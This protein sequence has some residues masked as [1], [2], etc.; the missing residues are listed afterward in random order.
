MRRLPPCWKNSLMPPMLR[1]TYPTFGSMPFSAERRLIYV[2]DKEKTSPSVPLPDD[3]VAEIK[4]AGT[5]ESLLVSIQE[6]LRGETADAPARVNRDMQLRNYQRRRI[7]KR[8]SRSGCR[9]E[10]CVYRKRGFC[11]IRSACSGIQSGQLRAKRR[12][13]L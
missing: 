1:K 12:Q 11:G 5:D 6:F 4:K 7:R 10:S 2:D 3:V 13:I 8:H 9:K